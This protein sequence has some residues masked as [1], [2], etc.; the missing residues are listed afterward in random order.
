MKYRASVLTYE[1]GYFE[2]FNTLAAAEQWLDT[3][4]NNYEYTTM[5]ETF[6]AAGHKIDGFFYTERSK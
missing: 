1:G 4:N 6:D 5:I 2:E 3:Q